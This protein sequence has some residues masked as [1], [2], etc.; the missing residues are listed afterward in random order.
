[1]ALKGS[2][3]GTNQLKLS[4]LCKNRGFS[5]LPKVLGT[6]R[7]LNFFFVGRAWLRPLEPSNSNPQKQFLTEILKFRVTKALLRPRSNLS[8]QSSWNHQFLRHKPS[9]IATSRAWC[10]NRGFSGLQTVPGAGKGLSEGHLEH[11]A[12]VVKTSMS[13]ALET[14][15]S[16]AQTS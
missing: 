10:T 16:E 2:F 8:V 7:Q 5:G 12:L 14:I 4:L 6:Q 13:R 15:V 1:M 9:K 3:W 11:E